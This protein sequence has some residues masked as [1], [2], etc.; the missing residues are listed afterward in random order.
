MVQKFKLGLNTGS[1]QRHSSV[2][3]GLTKLS[4]FLMLR[5]ALC[6]VAFSDSS[7]EEITVCLSCVPVYSTLLRAMQ[8]EAQERREPFSR[9]GNL[10]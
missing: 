6:H 1:V 9:Q 7:D 10:E 4:L 3:R 8:T 2:I 5:S